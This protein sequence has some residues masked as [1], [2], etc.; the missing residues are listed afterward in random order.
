MA[1]A[2]LQAL[3]L[4]GCSAMGIGRNESRLDREALHKIMTQNPLPL[5]AT[6][7][8]SKDTG[9]PF[10][11]QEFLILNVGD[12]K[13]GVISL[14]SPDLKQKE[15][16]NDINADSSNPVSVTIAADP[17]IEIIPPHTAIQNVLPKLKGANMVLLL[18][19]L[20]FTATKEI[21]TQF[22]GAID[23][24]ICPPLGKKDKGVDP[25]HAKISTTAVHGLSLSLLKVKF[26]D[27]G[28]I[29]NIV[30]KTLP[31][32]GALGGNTLIEHLI[33]EAHLDMSERII[34]ERRK[35]MRARNRKLAEQEAQK[36]Q[37]MSPLEY[38]E[39]TR[40]LNNLDDQG[41]LTPA[42]T[43][44]LLREQTTN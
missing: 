28:S 23:Y 24:A 14:L 12:I 29:T 15:D 34:D 36:Y 2:S 43:I 6:N 42:E 18:S 17:T 11:G 44:Q 38:I 32:D 5:V 35:I 40:I 39:N 7:V 31:I 1:A 41:D 25:Y 8:I 20:H 26:D 33:K 4:M 16:M 19:Q 3:N 37:G 22:A 10:V 13:I 27:G 30:N 21:M 9:K